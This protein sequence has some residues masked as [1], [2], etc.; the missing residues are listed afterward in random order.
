MRMLKEADFTA[1]LRVWSVTAARVL[2]IHGFVVDS[3]HGASNA[4]FLQVQALLVVLM[5]EVEAEGRHDD[6][7]FDCARKGRRCSVLV[8]Q[9]TDSLTK[10]ER[11]RMPKFAFPPFAGIHGRSSIPLT[12]DLSTPS[13]TYLETHPPP[14]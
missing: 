6:T 12:T 10:V 3:R 5:I 13:S 4:V 1:G 8:P 9:P 7:G 2:I 11:L 14:R